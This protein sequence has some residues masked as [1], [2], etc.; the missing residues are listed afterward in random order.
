[1]FLAERLRYAVSLDDL[2]AKTR[3]AR[4]VYLK[5]L[6]LLTLVFIKHLVVG[7]QAGLTLCLSGLGSHTHPF[8]FALQCLSAFALCFLLLFQ[9]T[10]LLLKPRAVVT[11]PWYALAAVEF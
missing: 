9:A 5:L 1:M 8:K 3:T 11:L 10:C 4:D 6:L 7:V 2:V